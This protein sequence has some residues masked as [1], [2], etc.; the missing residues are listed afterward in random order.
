MLTI[1]AI[2]SVSG[3]YYLST[4]SALASQEQTISSLQ[5]TVRS[6]VSHPATTTATSTTTSTVS[7]T[8][9]RF[10]YVPW[11]SF[12]NPVEYVSNSSDHCTGGGVCLTGDLR[13]AFLFA[14]TKAAASP[15]G[16][17]VQIN[18][19][20]SI[21]FFQVTI[22]YP[23]VNQTVN[24][25]APWANCALSNP[26]DHP[27]NQIPAYCIPIGGSAFVATIQGGPPA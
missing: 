3:A 5:S 8:D 21:A 23:Y 24:A 26:R 11:D 12:A 18:A 22:R 2:G 19:T 16:C 7:Y 27:G 15:Q 13:E 9:F 14:C 6:L 4:S 17:T 1:L 10:P 25:N 20:N